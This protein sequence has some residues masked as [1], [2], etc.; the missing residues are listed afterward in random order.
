MLGDEICKA[1]LDSGSMV[2]LL[3]EA[4]YRTL[5]PKPELLSLSDFQL[6]IRGA[7]DSSI[8]YTGYVI[9]DICIPS[10]DLPPVSVPVLIVP[11]TRYSASVPLIL[12]TN[13]LHH[14]KA[15]AL[16]GEL[17]SVWE[18]VF[19]AI[20]HTHSIPVKAYCY[21]AIV[22]RPYETRTTTGSVRK[23]DNIT[24]GVTETDGDSHHLNICPRLVK[25]NPNRS[26]SKIP[27]RVCNLSARPITIRPK[28]LLCN[29]QDVDVVRR[30]DPF[31]NENPKEDNSSKTLQEL[32]VTIPTD[33]LSSKE[34][35]V[36]TSFLE[37]WKHLF[38]TDITDLGCTNLVEHEIELSDPVPFK[39]PYRR[40][41]PGMY[42][43]VREHIKEML[44]AG[45]IRESHSPFSSNV[46]LVRK[47]D[48]SLRF[49]IDYR[50]LN[51]RTVKDAYSLP[52][53]EETIDCLS[54]SRYFSKLDLRS[55]W[56]H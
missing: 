55:G 38:S 25:V 42:E 5:A 8:H 9:L 36:A 15:S 39:D 20:A 49:C 56:F 35:S 26:F 47:K 41:P 14:F 16:S 29:L 6:D 13:V 51:N 34:L 53:I 30:V 4:F 18:E 22:V 43:E 28:S 24:L 11:D 52:R 27:V 50:R 48:S 33:T 17:P 44:D 40:I 54:G 46:V 21:K 1:L 12:G 10:V 2:T 3:S 37:K 32:G 23:T 45:A 31:E 19:S 7:G